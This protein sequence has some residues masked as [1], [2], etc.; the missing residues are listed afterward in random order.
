MRKSLICLAALLIGAASLSAQNNGQ[1]TQTQPQDT[2]KK[3]KTE[4]PEATAQKAVKETTKKVA[5]ENRKKMFVTVQGGGLLSINENFRAYGDDGKNSDLLTLQGSASFGYQFTPVSGVRVW[6]GYAGNRS[7]C[8]K[9]E[10]SGHRFYP[11][12]FNSINAFVDYVM[13]FSGFSDHDWTVVP[14]LYA[15]VGIGSTS[16]FEKTPDNPAPGNRFHPWQEV[17]TKNTVLGFRCGLIVE[18]MISQS[19]GILADFGGEF[20]MD[21]YNGLN[22]GDEVSEKGDKNFPLDFRGV[23]SLGVAIHF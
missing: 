7:A 6:A 10:T 23:A 8:N 12:K 13:D 16:G 22:T 15:G 14:K 17:S 19:F 20:Y 9:E 5:D 18:Y 2:T 1:N 4:V 21:D 11:Y 3:V